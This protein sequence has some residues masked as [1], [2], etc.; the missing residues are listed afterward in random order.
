MI[1]FALSVGERKEGQIRQDNTSIAGSAYGAAAV[2]EF[3]KAIAEAEKALGE[4]RTRAEQ[5]AA[6]AEV[7]A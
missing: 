3:L 1:N 7:L 6:E 5:I 2:P 4:L